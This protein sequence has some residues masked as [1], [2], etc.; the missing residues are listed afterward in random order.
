MREAIGY[1]YN[2]SEPDFSA[3]EYSKYNIFFDSPIIN[4]LNLNK[5]NR[6][7][8]KYIKYIQSQKTV[9]YETKNFGE[10]SVGSENIFSDI[11]LEYDNKEIKIGFSPLLLV[12]I[13]EDGLKYCLTIIDRYF[14]IFEMTKEAFVKT[15]SLIIN[16]ILKLK[17]TIEKSDNIEIEK[18]LGEFEYPHL[19]FDIKKNNKIFLLVKW[20]W[21]TF[22]VDIDSNGV[23]KVA[24]TDL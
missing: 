21:Y 9:K 8:K 10:I 24:D 14:E 12:S 11:T 23:M 6:K 15:G 18:T 19:Y 5:I 7:I 1:Y 17:S 3:L 13:D 16:S 22:E 4:I 20:Y 2:I